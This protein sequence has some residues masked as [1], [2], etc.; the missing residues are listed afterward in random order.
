[1]KRY[2]PLFLA[3]A[4]L[5]ACSACGKSEAPAQPTPPPPVSQNPQKTEPPPPEAAPPAD[6]VDVDLTVLSS[7]MV[8]AEVYNIMMAPDQYLG[9][10]IRMTGLFTVYQDPETQEIYCGVIVQDATACCSQGFDI[11]MP[12]G[13]SY[14]DDYPPAG[15]EIT[16]QGELQADR[17]TEE[18]GLLFLQLENVKILSSA[19]TP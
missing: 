2:L 1:M 18:E 17:S 10:I 9:K 14:P 3:A 11:I 16:V 5:L 6:G 15:T 13:L 8:Y 12:E 4:I 19:H 7:T